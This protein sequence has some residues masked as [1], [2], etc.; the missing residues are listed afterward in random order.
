[1]NI[2]GNIL[3]FK[4]FFSLFLQFLTK[5]KSLSIVG[6][7]TTITKSAAAYIQILL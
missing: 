6:I 7:D 4:I 2:G 5:V 3:F 1:V